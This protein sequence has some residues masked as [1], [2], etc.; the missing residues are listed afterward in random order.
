MYKP[1]Y[2]YKELLVIKVSVIKQTSTIESYIRR[3]MI[4][5]KIGL[6]KK[7]LYYPTV[8]RV[9]IFV[10]LEKGYNGRSWEYRRKRYSPRT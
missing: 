1:F 5:G 10:S 2:Y 7:I 3:F 8:Y 6:T 9:Y 4:N